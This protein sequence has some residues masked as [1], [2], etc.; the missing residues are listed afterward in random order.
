VYVAYCLDEA[1]AFF[2]ATIEQMLDEVSGKTPQQIKLQ[3]EMVLRKVLKMEQPFADPVTMGM[4]S[5]KE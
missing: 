3:R 2:G 1:T 4:V 5:P